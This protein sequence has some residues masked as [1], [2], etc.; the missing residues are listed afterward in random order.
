VSRASSKQD[1]ARRRVKPGPQRARPTQQ[2]WVK[3]SPMAG[4]DLQRAM[5]D[6]ARARPADILALQRT[7][8]NQAVSALIQAKLK[9][10]PAGDHYEREADRVADQV[11]TMSSISP[12]ASAS[13]GKDS[14][15]REASEENELQAKPLAASI[16]PLIQRQADQEEELQTKPLLQRQPG[17]GFEA[18]SDVESRLASRKG[19]GSPLP[20]DVRGFMEPRFG[21]DFSGVRVHTDGEAAQLARQVSAQAFTHGQDIYLGEGK[22]DPA[23]KTGKRLLAHELTHTIQQG[24]VAKNGAGPRKATPQAQAIQRTWGDP[25]GRYFRA[26]GYLKGIDRGLAAAVRKNT[27]AWADGQRIALGK[28][29]KTIQDRKHRKALRALLLCLLA[30]GKGDQLDEAKEHLSTKSKSEIDDVIHGWHTISGGVGQLSG[31]TQGF[32]PKL[33][34]SLELRYYKASRGEYFRENWGSNC[35]G[36]AQ[37]LLYLAGVVSLRWLLHPK[38]GWNFGNPPESFSFTE[39]IRDPD[40]ADDIE[41]GKLLMFERGGGTHF[42]V[43]TDTGRAWGHNNPGNEISHW[44]GEGAKPTMTGE[45]SI[46][47]WLRSSRVAFTSI[48]TDATE[49]EIKDNVFVRVASCIPTNAV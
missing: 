7:A 26:I 33:H 45:F 15:Q 8:G 12:R 19:G 40:K 22:Y 44:V 11:M 48:L 25:L 18:G 9:V 35:Y 21:A 24:A 49:K 34:G 16:T 31:A 46:S 39:T 23:S 32:N 37:G 27:K 5:A 42:A 4:R 20:D 10:G 17:G 2:H 1:K 28:L 13:R 36:G 29:G 43:S 30:H 14:L 47:D 38:S 41:P 3:P 6:P